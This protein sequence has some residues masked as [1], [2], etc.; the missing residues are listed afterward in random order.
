MESVTPPPAR[1][2]LRFSDKDFSWQLYQKIIH[3]PG[4]FVFFFFCSH[5]KFPFLMKV[6]TIRT[7]CLKAQVESHA[8]L[9]IRVYVLA[10]HSRPMK[11]T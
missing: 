6:H 4:V 9:P 7:V 2:L 8:L 5:V 3:V 11:G 1:G 10:G